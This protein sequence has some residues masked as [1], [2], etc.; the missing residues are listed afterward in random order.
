MQPRVAIT[1]VKTF[2]ERLVHAR[3]EA[4]LTQA[5]LAKRAR[6]AQSTVAS[7]ESGARKQPRQHI[8]I[9]D[10]C[11][12]SPHWLL[13][14]KGHM[15]PSAQTPALYSPTSEGT[16]AEGS[17]PFGVAESPA[18]WMHNLLPR[19]IEWEFVMTGTLPT[20]FCTSMPDTSMAPELRKGAT[21]VFLTDCKPVPG[22][23]VLLS[24][25]HGHAYVRE[26]RQTRPGSWEA[27]AVNPSYLPMYSDRDGLR[28]MAVFNGA[29][30]RRSER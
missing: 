13:Y 22:D 15:R 26:Y 20:S 12:V 21:L 19:M 16:K 25:R 8:A 1:P 28:V 14:G 30:G 3:Q 10:A 11:G 24:D 17:P 9:A 2:A 18:G 29:L 5:Q 7:A 4:G 23:F 27:H 6:V